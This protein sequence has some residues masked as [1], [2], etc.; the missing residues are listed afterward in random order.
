MV[1]NM[2]DMVGIDFRGSSVAWK[3]TQV[4]TQALLKMTFIEQNCYRF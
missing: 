3:S 4:E 1:K 2:G